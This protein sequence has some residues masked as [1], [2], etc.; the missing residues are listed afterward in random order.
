MPP[1]IALANRPAEAGAGIRQAVPARAF[2]S[3]QPARP[4]ANWPP[5]SPLSLR[6]RDAPGPE[7]RIRLSAM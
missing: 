3:F 1:T 5:F 4:T 6:L 2:P 7:F